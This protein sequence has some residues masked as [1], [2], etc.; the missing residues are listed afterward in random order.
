MFMK[1]IPLHVLMLSS[2]GLTSPAQAAIYVND[3][4]DPSTPF[5]VTLDS[6]SYS[7][8][9]PYG[10]STAT[11]LGTQSGSGSSWGE[12]TVEIERV[13]PLPGVAG[14]YS[15]YTQR[16]EHPYTY[17][18]HPQQFTAHFDA[19][20]PTSS[21]VPT[22]YVLTGQVQNLI[23]DQLVNGGIGEVSVDMHM[24]PRFSEPYAPGSGTATL[25][26]RFGAAPQA[27]SYSYSRTFD[28][29]SESILMAESLA[30]GSGDWSVADLSGISYF[31]AEF[32]LDGVAG[33]SVYLDAL[34]FDLT[35]RL[36]EGTTSWSE[37]VVHRTLVGEPLVL[38]AL[39]VPEASTY[40]MM[41]AGLSLVGLAA[42]RRS[43][44]ITRGA[45]NRAK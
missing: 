3:Q 13:E 1:K 22:T 6:G 10:S 38:P 28:L 20:H 7:W 16:L 25:E 23:G 14:S 33:T 40:G 19:S 21:T 18:Y 37:P 2:L 44:A 8:A 4:T 29:S 31:E 36:S 32:R 24:L 43:P 41:L 45:S 12:L 5:S 26:F 27:W 39:P 42:R 15:V 30:N 11:D 35:G 9:D 34:G 17:T